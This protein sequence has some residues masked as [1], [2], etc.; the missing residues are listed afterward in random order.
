M[1]DTREQLRERIKTLLRAQCLVMEG[2]WKRRGLCLLIT[3]SSTCHDSGESKIFGVVK[4]SKEKVE[5]YVCKMLCNPRRAEDLDLGG[6]SL[7]SIKRARGRSSWGT[8]GI[9]YRVYKNSERMRRRLLVTWQIKRLPDRSPIELG[10]WPRPLP[11]SEW[12]RH[13]SNSFSENSY[14]QR[15]V[16]QSWPEWQSQH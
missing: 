3:P 12:W 8:N 7:T 2:Y 5:E 15:K 9:P 16:V 1:K 4:A 6:R 10:T 11:V 14:E 13:R